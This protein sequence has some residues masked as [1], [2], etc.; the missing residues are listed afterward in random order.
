MSEIITYP[1]IELNVPP[2]TVSIAEREQYLSQQ[3]RNKAD[4]ECRAFLRLLPTLLETH[5]GHF[6]AIHDEQVVDCGDNKWDL[7]DRVWAKHG[8][9]AIHVELVTDEP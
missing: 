5:R 3:P 8:Y 1:P 2:R 6:V 7:A 9:V 4:R